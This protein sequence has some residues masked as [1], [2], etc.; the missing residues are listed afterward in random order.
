MFALRDLSLLD[1]IGDAA[2]VTAFVPRQQSHTCYSRNYKP[3]SLMST[4]QPNFVAA[5]LTLTVA[6]VPSNGVNDA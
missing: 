2:Y 1:V 4:L 6:M 5:R 3:Y